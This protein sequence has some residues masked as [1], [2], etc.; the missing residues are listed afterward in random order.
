MTSSNQR[1]RTLS[2]VCI[3]LCASS[4]QP[5]CLSLPLP[6]CVYYSVA[7]FVVVLIALS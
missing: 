6:H 7:F 5:V 3:Y 1:T 2:I 4:P